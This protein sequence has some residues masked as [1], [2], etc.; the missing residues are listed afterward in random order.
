LR[1]VRLSFRGSCRANWNRRVTSSERDNMT[2]ITRRLR[3][4]LPP[5]C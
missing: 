4:P 2:E 3:L 1:Q 5:R